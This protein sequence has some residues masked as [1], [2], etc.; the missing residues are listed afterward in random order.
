MLQNQISGRGGCLKDWAGSN[1]SLLQLFGANASRAASRIKKLVN[2]DPEAGL[3]QRK[4]VE[5]GQIISPVVDYQKRSE[6]YDLA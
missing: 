4:L 1:Q 3:I 5:F 2:F 6:W